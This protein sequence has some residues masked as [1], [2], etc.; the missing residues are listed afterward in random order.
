MGRV[1]AYFKVWWPSFG[2]VALG[3]LLLYTSVGYR[4]VQYV[5]AYGKVA[6]HDQSTLMGRVVAYF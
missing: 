4:I 2:N 5:L 1:V 3:W 6:Q